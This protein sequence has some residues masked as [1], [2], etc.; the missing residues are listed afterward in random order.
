[1]SQRRWPPLRGHRRREAP[2]GR[3]LEF[4]V[5]SRQSFVRLQFNCSIEAIL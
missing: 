4:P 3:L 1:M 2:S 5:F